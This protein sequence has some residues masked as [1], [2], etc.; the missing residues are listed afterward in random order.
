MNFNNYDHNFCEGDIYGMPEYFNALTS[1]VISAFGIMGIFNVYNKD[2]I[3]K[4]LFMILIMCGLGSVLYHIYGTIG[5]ALF[6]E[7]PMILIIFMTL[8][9]VS[10]TNA[11]ISSN[12]KSDP[13]PNIFMTDYFDF[14]TIKT[15]LYV[16]LMIS[17]LVLN[18]IRSNRLLFPIY[19]ALALFAV[20]YEINKFGN[21][22]IRSQ[23]IINKFKSHNLNFKQLLF[24]YRLT[25][26]L[27]ACFWVI[28]VQEN[29]I[30][31]GNLDYRVL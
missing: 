7:F 24:R 28:T 8:I 16:F 15:S 2:I 31:P 27:S 23:F 18:T 1:F 29:P 11:D 22:C 3:I 13:N 21:S 25:L 10:E 20:L 26:I 19:F 17:Y 4:M 12:S 9:I 30:K 14:Q 5:W 6:D